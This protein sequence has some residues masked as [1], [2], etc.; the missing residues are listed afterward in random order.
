MGGMV[1]HAA[2]GGDD[3]PMADRFGKKY[4]PNGQIKVSL[5]EAGC[6]QNDLDRRPTIPDRCRDLDAFDAPRHVEIHVDDPDISARLKDMDRILDI[7]C[8]DRFKSG[9][10]DHIDRFYPQDRFVF[11]GEHRMARQWL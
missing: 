4:C 6:G 7:R 1:R 3:F 9:V 2:H 5:A 8:L 11:D 10:F